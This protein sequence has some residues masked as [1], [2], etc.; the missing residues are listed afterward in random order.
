MGGEGLLRVLAERVG[1]PIRYING[2]LTTT[3]MGRG[4]DYPLLLEWSPSPPILWIHVWVWGRVALSEGEVWVDG[5]KNRPE[6][7]EVLQTLV[8]L[9]PEGFA[10]LSNR[11]LTLL[12]RLE[13][14]PLGETVSFRMGGPRE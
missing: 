12:G 7:R 8:A 4:L 10:P 5:L 3:L 6:V 11:L 14:L 13:G 1:S 2:F 9:V